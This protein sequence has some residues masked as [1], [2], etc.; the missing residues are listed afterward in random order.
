MAYS[1][2]LQ[3]MTFASWIANSLG[4][5]LVEA[6]FI[7]AAIILFILFFPIVFLKLQTYI[8]ITTSILS[9]SFLTAMGVL[10]YWVWAMI[11]L[12]VAYELAHKL[13]GFF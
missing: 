7:E 2:P 11:G 10:D 4:I 3:I 13:Q 6:R 9:M 12:Y 8:L 5:S 1:E